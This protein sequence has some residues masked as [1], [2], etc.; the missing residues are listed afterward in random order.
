MMSDSSD[1][2][3]SRGKRI[4]IFVIAYNAESH[5]QQ[6]LDR[7]AEGMWK[8]VS[9]VYIIDDCSSDNTVELALAYN[10]R[11]DKLVVLR[12]RINQRYGGNQKIGYQYALDRDLDIVVMLHADG[13]YAP[14]QLANL[15]RPLV[16]GEADVVLGTRMSPRKEALRGGMPRYKYLGNITLTAIQNA[17]ANTDLS[18]YHS[19][20]RAY[21]TRFL[22]MIPFW[23]NTDEWHFDTQILLQAKQCNARIVEVP[24]PTYYGNEICRVNGIL[25]GIH[26]IVTS[27]Q[28]YLFRKKLYY[29]RIFDLAIDG[30]RYPGKFDDRFSSHSLILDRLKEIG[31]TG[32]NVL[33]LGVGDVSL[34]KRLF[35]MG[36]I[37]DG[38][39]IDPVAADLARPYC[40]KVWTE[41][42]DSIDQIHPKEQYDIV[43]AADVLEHIK[44]PEEVLVSLKTFVRYGGVLIVSLP[45]IA[46]IYVRL[47]LVLGRFP[48]HSK[49]ILDRT[50]LHHYTLK[51]AGQILHR[52][53][54]HIAEKLVSIIPV[55]IVFPFLLKRPF[56]FILKM[57]FWV[58]RAMRGLFAYQ[59][60]F[61]CENP[62]RP[63]LL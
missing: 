11:S 31:V 33:D 3:D 29:S 40:R 14:E 9:T 50:H 35:E 41:S 56:R 10:D 1:G 43:I 13:Q 19:G 53:G 54:W 15:L 30:C 58:T 4:G 51:T 17:L 34:T 2:L 18:E 16:Q 25:Y 38:I 28:Y 63:H 46:N 42:A 49:G 22:R 57:L 20:Y 21:S 26:C 37:V 7:I 59:G 8:I 39:E 62:N 44:D 5:I 52:T 48:C 24:I 27:L 23:E 55:S 61:V 6:T 12:N 47:N 60:I 36:A 32:K 45:N